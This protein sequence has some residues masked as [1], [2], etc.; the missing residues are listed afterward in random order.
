MLYASFLFAQAAEVAAEKDGAPGGPPPWSPLPMILAMVALFYFLIFLPNRKEKRQRQ[1]LLGALKKNDKVIT[2]G[3]IIGVV[4]NLREGTD[5]VTIKSDETKL[6]VLRS[7]IARI[8]IE[9][10]KEPQKP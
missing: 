10:E 1:S 4:L 8:I 3:G 6:L 7:S 5:E 9:P 2:S